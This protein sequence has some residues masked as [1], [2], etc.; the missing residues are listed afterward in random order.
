MGLLPV[1]LLL[2]AIAV[3]IAQLL[4]PSRELRSVGLLLDSVPLAG[5]VVATALATLRLRRE[6]P[7]LVRLLVA[8][9]AYFAGALI[10]ALGVAHLAA[11]V[12]AAIERGPAFVYNFRSYSLVLLGVLLIVTGLVAAVQ[13]TRLGRGDGAAWRASL[14]VW[15]AILAINLPL[16]PLQGFAVGFSVLAALALLLLAAVRP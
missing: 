15:T 10:A 11:V 9:Y 16:A 7:P 5:V 12:M 2:T 4:P 14:W 13:A 1:V 6:S 3:V 8:V